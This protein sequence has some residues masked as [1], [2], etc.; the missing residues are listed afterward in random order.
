MGRGEGVSVVGL[1][2][3]AFRPLCLADGAGETPAFPVSARTCP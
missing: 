2:T 3:R 1:G